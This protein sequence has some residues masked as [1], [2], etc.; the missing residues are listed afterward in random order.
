MQPIEYKLL[1][2]LSPFPFLPSINPRK[3]INQIK[4]IKK[5]IYIGS[6]QIGWHLS[7]D[8]SLSNLMKDEYKFAQPQATNPLSP[9]L[10][11][12]QQI[13][14]STWIKVQIPTN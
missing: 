6:P 5:V 4:H 1:Y 3:R 13:K 8:K 7:S 9:S 10:F 2:D 11:I 12:A 14:L